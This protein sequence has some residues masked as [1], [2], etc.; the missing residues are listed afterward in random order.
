MAGTGTLVLSGNNTFT[1]PTTIE[2]GV[3][4]LGAPG[5]L[6]AGTPVTLTTGA[7]LDL[8]GNTAT[9]GKLEGTGG[10]IALTGASLTVNQSSNTTFSGALTGTGGLVKSGGGQLI[11]SGTQAFT[12]PT[13]INDGD[14]K[15]NG[16]AAGSTFT[17]TGGTL[18]GTGTV[19]P[20]TVGSGGTLSPG[21]SPGLLVVNGSLSLSGVTSME[22]AGTARGAG[23]YDAVD[24]SGAINFGGTL[25]VSLINGYSP[26]GGETF[27]LFSW[28][29]GA[30]STFG[31]VNLPS[32]SGGLNWDTSALYGTGAIGVIL[33][34]P[35]PSTTAALFGGAILA[36]VVI[37]RRRQGC[38]NR[39]QS[40]SSRTRKPLAV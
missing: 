23:G 28:G 5:A 13:T 35:E 10:S 20:L 19:G 3:V 27:S 4:V 11:L 25:T 29:G 12:G 18:S 30:T 8:N 6:P 7:T 22:L 26:T 14:L 24:V 38:W 15:I 17:V 40:S 1:G 9:L 16:S 36:V 39:R 33:A 34:I 32:L 37:R 31:T 21:S 2:S